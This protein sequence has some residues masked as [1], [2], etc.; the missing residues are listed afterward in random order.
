[1][2]SLWPGLL[3][4]PSLPTSVKTNPV[5]WLS[6][7]GKALILPSPWGWIAISLKQWFSYLS[8]SS[9]SPGRLVKHSLLDLQTGISDPGG[10]GQAGEYVLLTSSQL[11]WCKWPRGSSL[12]TKPSISLP[13][14]DLFSWPV[15]P[16]WAL[17]QVG[18]SAEGLGKMFLDKK[19][20]NTE[21]Y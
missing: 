9:A 7:S 10:Q 19:K 1:M 11:H 4:H 2:W 13:M 3:T 20:K 17:S 21:T 12:R 16:F 18:K 5:L 6:I 15:I 14:S 8:L